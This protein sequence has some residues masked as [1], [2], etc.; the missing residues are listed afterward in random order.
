MQIP[1]P[2]KNP[3]DF[4]LNLRSL[5]SLQKDLSIPLLFLF[6]PLQALEILYLKYFSL[7]FFYSFFSTFLFLFS[8]PHIFFLC[9]IFHWGKFVCFAK[10]VS[11][12]LANND[13]WRKWKAKMAAVAVVVVVFG[14][15]KG[16][17]LKERRNENLFTL[18]CYLKRARTI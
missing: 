7:F 11:F 14:R 17:N 1:P 6:R 13:R 8:F 5:V 15:N 2:K 18:M 9:W 10:L 16:I 12:R 4:K 3:L